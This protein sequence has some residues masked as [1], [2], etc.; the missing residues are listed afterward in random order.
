MLYTA[1]LFEI[2]KAFYNSIIEIEFII[3]NYSNYRF[4]LRLND[5]YFVIIKD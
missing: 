5:A 1:H 3:N 4:N 2:F